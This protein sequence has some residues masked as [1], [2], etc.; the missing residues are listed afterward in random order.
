MSALTYYIYANIYILI[1]WG[2]FHYV[3]RKE[4]FFQ[5]QRLFILS[6]V[7][8]SVILPLS[9]FYSNPESVVYTYNPINFVVT[10][11]YNIVNSVITPVS[12]SKFSWSVLFKYMT[13]FGGV[14]AFLFLVFNYIRIYSFINNSSFTT[15]GKFRIFTS[16]ENITPFIYRRN[17]VVPNILSNQEREI[18][19][20]HEF[21]HYKM[22]HGIDN[23]LFQVFQIIFWFNPVIYLLK[24]DLKEIHEFQVDQKILN[25]DIDVSIYKLTLVK[26]SVGYQE[27]AI[28]NGLSNSKIKNRIEMMNKNKTVSWKWKFLLSIPAFIVVFSLVSFGQSNIKSVSSHAEQ[29]GLTDSIKIDFV[30][31]PKSAFDKI[32][33]NN[34][35]MVF[36]N[37]NSQLLIDNE[38]GSLNEVQQTVYDNFI[39]KTSKKLDLTANG[40][41]KAGNQE[42]KIYV[43]KDVKTKETDYDKLVENLSACISKIQDFYSNKVF[44]K[45]FSAL[46][47]DEQAQISNL[48]QPRI[49]SM[50]TQN[51]GHSK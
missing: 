8:I 6:S 49:Y 29:I 43:R 26:F 12:A 32:D 20:K 48:I 11:D 38:K 10:S 19:I 47:G 46:T 50:E 5:G 2:F 44:S 51:I 24:K 35:V 45:S 36:I 22:A 25:S 34:A 39:Q 15:Y 18:A 33:I 9:A 4:T 27:F 30:L 40:F 16:S 37:K 42:T 17:I 1:F 7:I 3:L 28:A 21:Q 13:F 41:L 23:I 31:V 14:I